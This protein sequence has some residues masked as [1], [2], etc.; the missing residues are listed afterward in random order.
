MTAAD[1]IICAGVVLNVVS[2]AMQGFFAEAL[3]MAGLMFG[4]LCGRVAV[5]ALGGVVG[6][7]F[8]ARS[9]WLRFSVF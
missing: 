6:V 8:E 3:S 7:V 2:A 5:S 4:Y 9:G 1:W